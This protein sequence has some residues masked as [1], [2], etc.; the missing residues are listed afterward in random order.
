LIAKLGWREA[1]S[2]PVT[3][4]CLVICVVTIAMSLVASLHTPVLTGR[5]LIVLLPAIYLAAAELVSALAFAWGRLAGFTYLAAQLVLMAQPSFPNNGDHTKEQWRES[6]QFVLHVPGC[7]AETIHVY[8]EAQ[9]YRFYTTKLRPQLR[10]SEIPE[11]GTADLAHQPIS[12]CPILL[13][14]V[15]VPEWDLDGL[16][17]TAGLDSSEIEIIGWYEAYVVL[18]KRA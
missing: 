6:A 7:A 4:A 13:W 12:S 14:I 17:A 11:G 2:L 15:G 16:L 8:G 1:A 18:A 5:N 3:S 10:L 9:Y